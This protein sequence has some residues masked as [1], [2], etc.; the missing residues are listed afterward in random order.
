MADLNTLTLKQTLDKLDNKKISLAELYQDLDQ[1]V[2]AD[3]KKLNIYLNLNK[4]GSLSK[5]IYLA[6]DIIMLNK[7]FIGPK[8]FNPYIFKSLLS[9][10][11]NEKSFPYHLTPSM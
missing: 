11:N 7:I 10:M 9:V 3:N 4:K 1:A 8:E 2:V 5:A 6:K